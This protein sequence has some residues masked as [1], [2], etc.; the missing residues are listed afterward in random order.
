MTGPRKGETHLGF[1]LEV[2]RFEIESKK[3]SQ[4][5]QSISALGIRQGHMAKL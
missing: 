1:Y 3:R 2:I 4:I 5:D